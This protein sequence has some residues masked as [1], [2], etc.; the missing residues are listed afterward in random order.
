[1]GLGPERCGMEGAK[2]VGG[3]KGG[4]DKVFR[5]TGGIRSTWDYRRWVDELEG[6]TA[7]EMRLPE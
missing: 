6:R 1:M 2:E 3:T 5:E 4:E 7:W